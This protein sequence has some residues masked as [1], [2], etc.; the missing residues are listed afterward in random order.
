M[1]TMDLDSK[2]LLSAL[3]SIQGRAGFSS[4]GVSPFFFPGLTLKGLGEIAFPFSKEQASAFIELAEAAPYGK[5]M[6]TKYD[7]TVRKC[8]QLDA[9]HFAFKSPVWKRHLDATLEKIREDLGITGAISAQPYKLL[10]YGPG[11]HFKAHRDTEKLD[12]M[13]G[14]LIIA[15]PSQHDGGQLHIRHGGM[16]TTVNF[17][18]EAHRHDFQHAAFFADCEHEVVPVTS[19]YRFCVVYNLVLEEGDPELLNQSADDHARPLAMLLGKDAGARAPGAPTVILLEHHY[20]EVNFRS[21]GSR[22]MTVNERRRCSR[23]RRMPG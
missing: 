9:K 23:R 11:G 5:G 8:W 20:T 18:A 15:L 14:T 13:F 16:E 17:S 12:A 10:L 3:N 2:V 21:A 7:E 22:A 6:K 19:G 4:V 1:K